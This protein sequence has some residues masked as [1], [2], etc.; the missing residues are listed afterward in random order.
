[1]IK[2]LSVDQIRQA[3]A[4]TI[5][6]EPIHSIDLMERAATAIFKRI[7]PGLTPETSIQVFAGMGNNGGDGL[8]IARLL[9]Q[10]NIQVEVFILK[11]GE[12]GSPDFEKNLERLSA[13]DCPYKAL[14]SESDIPVIPSTTIVI[15]AL[16]GSGLNKPILGF[17]GQ[18]IDHINNSGAIV[19]AIDMP[20]GLYAD[21][22][23]EDKKGSIIK[24]DY[25]YTFQWPK[26][27]MLFP[28]NEFYFG[29]WEV[30]PIGLH[31]DFESETPVSTYLLE[32]SD[33]KRMLRTRKRFAHKGSFGHALLIAGSATK[34]GA[35]I[36]SAKACI[37]SG[38][39]LLHTHLPQKAL[40][41]MQ[42]SVPEAMLSIDPH[43]DYFSLLPDIQKFSAVGIGPGIGTAEETSNAMKLLIQQA[44]QPLVIDADGL[45]ILS[46]HKTW[47]A[48][49]PKNSI[50]TPHPGEFERLAGKWGN[51]FEKLDIQR[52]MAIR[53]HIIVILKG[54]FTSIAFPDGSICFNPTGNAGMATAGSGDVLTGII[55]G[56][57]A[58]GYKPQQAAM[59]AV[60]LHG[61]AGDLAANQLSEE[62]LIA[63]DIIQELGRA[64]Q[65]IKK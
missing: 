16:F 13:A 37:R 54:A 55:L 25:T 28:E 45:N 58:S 20:S 56:L 5:S 9:R 64:F 31:P 38:V 19:I 53:F 52:Q 42:C 15:D 43:P 35:A 4:Y 1:M 12:Q 24:A 6:N 11:T 29:H 36:L 65:T 22:V 46:E 44:T 27:S 50:L 30:V 26:L 61:L 7:L 17:A 39:G 48:F 23:S 33:I 49:L 47:L 18:L 32:Q 21:K 63:T 2:I 57:L 8:V 3:D 60:Y 59:I 34:S 41:P 51:S 14:I 40:L 10:Q 62:S